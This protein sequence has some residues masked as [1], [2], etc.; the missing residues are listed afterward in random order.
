MPDDH[1]YVYFYDGNG[2]VGQVVEWS[3]D[4][5]GGA[6]ALG[7]A[8]GDARRA[9]RYEYDP[10]GRT[11]GPDT[12]GDGKFNESQDNPGPYAATN[13]FRFSTKYFDTETRLGYWGYR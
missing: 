11:V 8:W 2:N 7:T 4:V 13:P 6:G 9:A 10:Y 5:S 12:T 1:A 3:P